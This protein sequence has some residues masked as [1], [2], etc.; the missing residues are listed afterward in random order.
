M[1]AMNKLFIFVFIFWNVFAWGELEGIVLEENKLSQLLPVDRN[2]ASQKKIK[3][4]K[5]N[6]SKDILLPK[7]KNLSKKRK[8]IPL[9]DVEP[10]FSSRLYY[11]QGTD[12]AELETILNQE[13]SHLFKLLKKNRSADLTLRLG[14][15]YVDKARFITLKL[16]IDYEKNM[17]LFEQG[18]T[19]RKPR[20]NLRTAENYNR[21]AL[22]LFQSFRNRYPK[23]KRSD[24]VLFF[25]GFNSYQLGLEEQGA[26]H[27]K[28][29]A[30][31][32][33]QS[34]YLYEAWFQ[35]GEHYFTR[36][37][38]EKSFDYY[39]KV[40][41]NK[42][43]KFYFFALYKMAWSY[44]KRGL[45]SKGLSILE[46]IIKEG[47]RHAHTDGQTQRF[48]F[49]SEAIGDLV[50]FYTYSRRSPQKAESWLLT[51]LNDKQTDRVLKKLAYAYRDTG[52]VKG[53]I[54]L[55]SRLI[56]KDSL[57]PDAFDYKY[58][59]V[60]SI[61]SH[62]K[63][64]QILYQFKDWVKNY[65]KKSA[66]ASQNSRN[67]S[68][69][70]KANNLIEVTLRNYSL[71]NHQT[72][73]ISKNKR[74]QSI[75]LDLYKLYF[76]EFKDS[77]HLDQIHFFY[78][79]LLF[80]SRKYS[81]AV[82]AYE[83]VIKE[84][85]DT[86][87]AK[88]A[89][90]NQLLALEKILPSDS[91]IAKMTASTDKLIPF[92]EK[93]KEFIRVSLRYLDNFPKAENASAVLY[94]AA[95]LHYNFNQYTQAAEL[96]ESLI[97]KYP[98]SE[99][100]SSVGGLLLD[101]Y[102]KDK[103]YEA[104][105]K[106]ATSLSQ[107]KK[108]D[109][110][111][112]QEAKYILEQLSF[113][114][115]QD[116]AFKKDYKKSADLYYEFAKKKP[117]GQLALVSYYNAAI[118]YE[119]IKN[120]KQATQMYKAVLSYKAQTAKHK[121]IQEKSAEFLPVLHEK[122]G[123]YNQAAQGYVQYA[124]L[125]PKNPKV[126]DYWYNAGIIFDALNNT[127]Q[128][129]NAYDK[130]LKLSKSKN[131]Y[132]VLHILGALH[133]RR[134]QYSKA[135]A[136]YEK[137]LNS[138]ALNKLTLVKSAFHIADIYERRLKNKKQA[139]TWHRRT[140]AVYKKFKKGVTYG[141]RSHFYLVQEH[142]RNFLKVKIPF[143]A[144]QQKVAVD[145]KIKLLKTLESKLKPI[146]KY[147]DGEQIIASLVLIGLANQKMAEAIYKTPIPKQLRKEDRKAYKDGI[148]KVIQPYLKEAVK[149][150]ELALEKAESFQV[151]SDW[152]R[153]AHRGLK[154]IQFDGSEFVGFARYVLLPEMVNFRKYDQTGAVTDSFLKS[155]NATLK[156]GISK[157]DLQSISQAI[158]SKKEHRVLKVVSEV[159]NKDPDQI[160]AINSLALFYF[161]KNRLSLSSFIMNRVLNK[162]ESPI[163]L[164]NLGIIALRYGRVR[165]AVTY[166]KKSLS[167][168]SSYKVAQANLASIFALQHDYENAYEFYK[169]SHN[170][171]VQ[172]KKE[173]YILFNNYGASAMGIKKWKNSAA[174][175][176]KLSSQPSPLSE[177]LFNYALVL[178]EGFKDKDR[179]KEAEKLVNELAFYTKSKIFK[180]K[181]DKLLKNIK[182]RL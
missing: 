32:Y 154:T 51:F 65:G 57:A 162:K 179:L 5:I 131:R 93:I 3:K 88:P 127:Q 104:L 159:L 22:K 14:S 118:N 108:V 140:L 45:A 79:E 126:V 147:N 21:K 78:G 75:A 35:L 52:H 125:Y 172:S 119:K 72:F 114:Q 177:T 143:K 77:Q 13:I 107:S 76:S 146:I 63:V 173:S 55:F 50:L 155:M 170:Q 40:S 62:G 123:Y 99:Y 70:E 109:Q 23:H 80:D 174:L 182:N 153:E 165:E 102:N 29:L 90:I 89:Y 49:V 7:V 151:Y 38:W 84:Y 12:E 60:N 26:Q 71:K 103:N 180:K 112:L 61:Y 27:F 171:P 166:F 25:L 44:Y 15:L 137:H 73:R 150:Y 1:V 178:T 24:E 39:K 132:N 8:T 115:A 149:S 58:Q 20:L 4:S 53:V 87:Y 160:L 41:K 11:P 48:T 105:T 59:I 136:Y 158:K 133:E 47:R 37:N 100:V 130:Y 113:K 66:W 2:L 82:K 164:N 152:I 144:A 81:E 157:E 129:L 106:L 176:K 120:I 128:A 138:P 111:L 116:F 96:L 16:Q 110:E 169:S 121:N 122:L 175:L 86:K 68:L 17:S 142:Y 42:R 139:E 54:H 101:I 161:Q 135:I 69:V 33:P 74:G 36:K 97:K 64:S 134:R 94:K 124:T 83:F 67:R 167:E 91:Q 56:D 95:I 145:K 85:E 31:L 117:K 9:K 156:H 30:T 46:R 28:T 19:K 181:L 18:K 34:S 98:K 6:R 92:S 141:A 168:Q 43:N 10:P 148:K 163:L